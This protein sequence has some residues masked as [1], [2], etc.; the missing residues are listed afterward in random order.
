MAALSYC[1]DAALVAIIRLSLGALHHLRFPPQDR[2]DIRLRYDHI[3]THSRA[4]YIPFPNM[5]QSVADHVWNSLT[6]GTS[7]FSLF[8]KDWAQRWP[9]VKWAWP[10]AWDEWEA[11][12]AQGH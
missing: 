1:D 10:R 2:F 11:G 7:L 3:A 4:K 9:G 6:F 8:G 5:P 12:E